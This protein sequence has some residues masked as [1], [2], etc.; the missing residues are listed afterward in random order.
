MSQPEVMK[1]IETEVH[2]ILTELE[3]KLQ[4]VFGSKPQIAEHV[5]TARAQVS[6]VTA[7]PALDDATAPS[8]PSEPEFN[9]GVTNDTPVSE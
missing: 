5:A 6:Q 7:T 1:D 2:K 8:E 9:L 4:A 3:A